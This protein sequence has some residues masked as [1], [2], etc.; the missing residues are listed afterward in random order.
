M[1]SIIYLHF[2]AKTV[3]KC[4]LL[5]VTNADFADCN[6]EYLYSYSQR[7]SWAPNRPVFVHREKDRVIF[8]NSGGLGEVIEMGF[9][10]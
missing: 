7:V 6:G 10:S 4:P 9:S 1:G 8:W 3:P 2:L 5:K